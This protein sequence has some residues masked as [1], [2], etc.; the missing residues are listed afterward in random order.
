MAAI[1]VFFCFHAKWR[2]SR[3]KIL[4]NFTFESEAIRANLHGNKRILKWQP[5]WNKVYRC[6]SSICTLV[7][8]VFELVQN[9]LNWYKIVW[10]G[11]ILICTGEKNSE[12]SLMFVE[13]KEHTS[14]LPCIYL[15]QEVTEIRFA[16][17][18]GQ[19]RNSK[20]CWKYLT[21]WFDQE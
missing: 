16:E 5:F 18:S 1:L 2:R 8:F 3:L 12:N 7:Q 9:I 14:C 4:L 20:T 21:V 19:D 15:V 17:H 6:C 10:T 13:H 11:T